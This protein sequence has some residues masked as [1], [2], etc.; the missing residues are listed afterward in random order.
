MKFFV[1]CSL[2]IAGLHPVVAAAATNHK[3]SETLI[4]RGDAKL[5]LNDLDARMSRFSEP[6]RADFAYRPENLARLMDQL[7]LNRQLAIQARELGIDQNEIVKRDIELAIE[8]VLAVHRL[9]ALVDSAKPDYEQLARERYMADPLAHT[10]PEQR[11]VQHILVSTERRSDQDAL[12]MANEIRLEALQPNVE[13]SA[14]V[15]RYSDD[16]AKASNKGRYTLSNE[17]QFVPEFEAAIKALSELGEITQPVKTKFGYHIIKLIEIVPTSRKTFEE[18]K[19]ELVAQAS[20]NHLLT[21]RENY[22]RDMRAQPESGNKQLLTEL[23]K[24]YGGRPTG[25]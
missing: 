15:G 22:K 21:V 6:E 17:G 14:L 20:I 9:N 2:L 7:L 13:F 4:A 23:P 25:R 3:E 11:V 12:S 8:E 24:R 16:S 18:V 19:E 1:I 10:V 5:S